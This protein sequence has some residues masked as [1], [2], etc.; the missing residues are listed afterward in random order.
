ML[1]N[2]IIMLSCADIKVNVSNKLGRDVYELCQILG[3]C[4]PFFGGTFTE[5]PGFQ[6][7]VAIPTQLL[8]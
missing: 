5:L 6:I 1:D 8:R 4:S 7:L 3:E 2:E